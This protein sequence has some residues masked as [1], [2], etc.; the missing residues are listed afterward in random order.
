MVSTY[1]KD[2]G[3]FVCKITAQGKRGMPDLLIMNNGR[4]LFL[5]LKAP[6][7]KPTAQQESTLHLLRLHGAMAQWAS[8]LDE[9]IALIEY[10]CDQGH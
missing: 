1:C 9:C 5:E 3:Y 7:K 10:V 8:N 6:G 2:K 4:V